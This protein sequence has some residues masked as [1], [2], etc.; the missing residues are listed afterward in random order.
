[1]V[2]RNFWTLFPTVC[3]V[4][5][6]NMLYENHKKLAM[7]NIHVNL[8]LFNYP[9]ANFDSS[10]LFFQKA[11]ASFRWGNLGSCFF[12]FSSKGC[13]NKSTKFLL[14]TFHLLN[15]RNFV[16]FG[17]AQKEI[18]FDFS[19]VHYL[20]NLFVNWLSLLSNLYIDT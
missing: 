18:I 4:R 8:G 17:P 10:H 9:H 1:M 19:V 12:Q 14:S 5:W 7:S 3:Y 20:Q 11:A 13:L 2:F 15:V 6:C 16:S